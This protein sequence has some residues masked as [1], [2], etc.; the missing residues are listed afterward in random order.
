ML[1]KLRASE[2]II[3][4]AQGGFLEVG[5]ALKAIQ[6][7]KLF[8]AA[9]CWDFDVYCLSKWQYS[10]TYAYRLIAAFNCYEA[11]SKKFGPKHQTLPTNE[12]QLR[13]LSLLPAKQW[14][15]AWEEVL[16]NA[17]T[18][19]ITGELVAKIVNEFDYCE[20]RI[21]ARKTEV[22]KATAAAKQYRPILVVIDKVLAL[23]KA[24]LTVKRLTTAMVRIREMVKKLK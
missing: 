11:L 20:D 4:E 18:M 8:L 22:G 19:P 7:Q 14:V 6:S 10:K 2:A 3:A 23:K 24:D 17:A 13:K 9:G 5:K 16:K 1:N 15:P 12:L 21:V